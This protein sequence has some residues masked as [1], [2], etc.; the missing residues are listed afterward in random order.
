MFT[1]TGPIWSETFSGW[2]ELVVEV[3]EKLLGWG[4]GLVSEARE[5]VRVS[6]WVVRKDC[7]GGVERVMGGLGIVVDFG[8]RG[9]GG[10]GRVVV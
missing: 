5:R 7:I 1:E 2:V 4:E 10:C 8:G 6:S 9:C 3:V